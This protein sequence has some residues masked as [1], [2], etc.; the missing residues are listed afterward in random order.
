MKTQSIGVVGLGKVGLPL[1]LVMAKNFDVKGVDINMPVV[2]SILERQGFSE[3]NV[4][5]YLK[6][7]GGHLDIST[8][9]AI[10]ASCNVVF[11]CVQTPS[12]PEGRFSLDYVISAIRGL[13][14]LLHHKSQILAIVSTVNP[15]DMKEK[16]IPYLSRLGILERTKGVCYNPAMITL[17]NAIHGFERPDYVLI[18]ESSRAAG[19]ELEKVWRQVVPRST[20]IIRGSIANI[21]TAKFALNLALVSKITLINRVAEFCEAAGA[22]IDFIADI[23]KLEPR[24]AGKR[25]FKGGLGFGGPCFPRDV[26]A[27]K[28]ACE[29]LGLASH[30]CDAIRDINNDQVVRSVEIIESFGSKRVGML[31]VTYKP[32]TSLIVE[33]Q[34]L[35]IAQ[36]LQERGHKVTVYDPLGMR[37][38]KR[39][40]K[41]ANFAD[42]MKECILD[43]EIVFVGVPWPEFFKLEAK[44]FRSDQ[45]VIDPWRVLRDKELPCRYVPYGLKWR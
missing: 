14:E 43:N 29:R 1:A 39:Q 13:S 44:D 24:I 15:T 16:I 35:Q 41:G 9:Y 17:G 3:T 30:L 25:M 36:A 6:R 45:I 4:N 23:M 5:E 22:D 37:N 40:L 42:N 21:E 28:K 27:F 31:G 12:T 7:Y 11:V 20:P 34:A 8:D 10:T 33:S 18:G 32:N 2:R 19:A 38:A 26:V